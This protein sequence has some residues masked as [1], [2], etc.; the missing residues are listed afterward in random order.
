MITKAFAQLA[1]QVLPRARPTECVIRG[2]CRTLIFEFP[3]AE[4][5]AEV[6]FKPAVIVQR[7][8][9]KATLVSDL[10]SYFRDCTGFRH[11][12]ICCSLRSKIKEV[13]SKRGKEST[14]WQP[15][16]VVLEQESLCETRMDEG[17]CIVV[18]Q[19]VIVGGLE[20]ED[21]ILAW[22]VGGSPWP[23]VDESDTDFV[24]VVLGAVKIVQDEVTVI[25][26]LVESECF[27]DESGRVVYPQT[28][29]LGAAA[30]AVALLSEKEANVAIDRMRTITR[31]LGGKRDVDKERIDNLVDSLRLE[32]IDTDSY[33][34]AW[35]LSLFESVKA[36]LSGHDKQQFNQR[37]RAYRKQIGHPTA[38]TRMD[39]NEFLRLQRD[40]LAELRRI[41]L[42]E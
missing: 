14:D 3:G 34:R 35:Y 24:N 4:L 39:S 23:D 11:Y 38:R 29:Q 5:K 41:Y 36:V 12:T 22:Q 20:G 27:Y 10:P 2:H 28:A 30:Q 9:A 21:S 33:R 26:E 16:Y 18:D 32:K 25:R 6:P 1:M 8:G 17:T 37:H 42:E 13:I 31:V 19:K 40:S 7:A 15:L